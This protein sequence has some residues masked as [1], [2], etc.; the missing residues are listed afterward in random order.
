MNILDNHFEIK[1][2]FI[3][4]IFAQHREKIS[5]NGKNATIL[6]ALRGY[7]LRTSFLTFYI[8]FFVRITYFATPKAEC[9]LF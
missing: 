3:F 8:P 4:H 1:L 6:Y 2:R 9:I 7:D 5:F